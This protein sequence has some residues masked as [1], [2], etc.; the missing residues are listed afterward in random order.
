MRYSLAYVLQCFVNDRLICTRNGSC[1]Q[2]RHKA[3]AVTGSVI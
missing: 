2:V 1:V 3:E